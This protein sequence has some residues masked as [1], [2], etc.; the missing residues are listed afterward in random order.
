[1]RPVF[2]RARQAASAPKAA[3]VP[4]SIMVM[5]QDG[6][7]DLDP[8]RRYQSPIDCETRSARIHR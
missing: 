1:M 3:S 7:S 4:L 5:S 8:Q 2:T 6:N